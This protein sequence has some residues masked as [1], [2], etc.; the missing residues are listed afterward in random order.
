MNRAVIFLSAL[1]FSLPA[2]A[3]GDF[4][5]VALNSLSA[6]PKIV[7]APVMDRNGTIIG[8]VRAVATDQDGRPSAI[9]YLAGNRLM[10][11]AAPAVSYDA[12]KNLVVADTA[13]ARLD[14]QAA[15]S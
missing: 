4:A 12:Q 8:K 3:A 9:S 15:A 7:S 1:V 11:V 2:F 14:R 5:P 6:A 10:V 13:K